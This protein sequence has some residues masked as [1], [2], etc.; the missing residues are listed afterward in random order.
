MT[1][2]ARK[3]TQQLLALRTRTGVHAACIA[4]EDF[5][6]AASAVDDLVGPMENNITFLKYA[7][8][9]YRP[10]KRA[11]MRIELNADPSVHQT[12]QGCETLA[13]FDRANKELSNECINLAQKL[14]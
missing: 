12:T 2:Q 1:V 7:T 11:A 3:L 14:Y 8:D 4:L 5:P 10:R 6:G 13:A 9:T